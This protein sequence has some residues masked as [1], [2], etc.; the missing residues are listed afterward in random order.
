PA[1]IHRMRARGLLE[2]GKLAEAKVEAE[3][4]LAGLPGDVELAIHLLPGLEGR[5][6]KKDAAR[7]FEEAYGVYEDLCREY[8]KAAWAHNSAAWLSACCRRNLDKG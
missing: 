4:C 5:G 6:E 1:F 3:R 8:P 7:L 2:A